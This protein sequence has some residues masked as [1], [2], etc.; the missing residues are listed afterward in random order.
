MECVCWI[1]IESYIEIS[2]IEQEGK[3]SS[4]GG[5]RMLDFHRELYDEISMIE[6]VKC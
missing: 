6:L 5:M 2:M 1:S 4:S 3:N